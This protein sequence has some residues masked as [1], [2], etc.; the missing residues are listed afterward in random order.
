[1]QGCWQPGQ[2]GSD[3]NHADRTNGPLS[4]GQEIVATANDDGQIKLFRY[5][6]M[7]DGGAGFKPLVGHSS[8]VTKVRFT[9]QNK[10]LFSLGGNDT[11]VMQWKITP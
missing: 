3:I 1:M 7:I 9:P 5:P 10:Y 2:D 6:Q 4:S 8:H 11:T